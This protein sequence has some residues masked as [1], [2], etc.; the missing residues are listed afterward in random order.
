MPETR[1]D[2]LIVN[3]CTIDNTNRTVDKFLIIFLINYLEF[4][5]FDK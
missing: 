2:L 4:I 1:E 3:G 5:I